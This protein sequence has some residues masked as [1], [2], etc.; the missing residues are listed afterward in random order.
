MFEK[1]WLASSSCVQALDDAVVQRQNEL[2]L[3][4]TRPTKKTKGWRDEPGP[5]G[6]SGLVE[7]A[8]SHIARLKKGDEA[9][10]DLTCACA[11]VAELLA[12]AHAHGQGDTFK[13]VA[14]KDDPDRHR[15]QSPLLALRNA[16]FHPGSLSHIDLLA[17]V[18]ERDSPQII[19]GFKSS[20]RYIKDLKVAEWALRKV[21]DL[22]QY[23]LARIVLERAKA[24]KVALA[25]DAQRRI[26]ETIDV[27]A[28]EGLL[29]KSASQ[30]GLRNLFGA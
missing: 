19:A 15:K 8:E 16:V 23:E 1:S 30:K 7:L 6:V 11:L 25:K 27:K 20:P 26:L 3:G 22:G 28:M 9:A 21:R 17:R 29:E 4:G 12:T 14:K 2:L 5:W 13:P 24:K 10:F 18:V